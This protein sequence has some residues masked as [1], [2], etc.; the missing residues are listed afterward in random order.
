MFV[1]QLL[2]H[3]IALLKKL[4][5]PPLVFGCIFF[6]FG[7][8]FEKYWPVACFWLLV[9]SGIFLILSII[10]L[11]HRILPEVCLS[12]VIFL[13]GALSLAQKQLIPKDSIFY[14]AG[15]ASRPVCLKGNVDSE[16]A[17]LFKKRFFLLK[18]SRLI[19]EG[20]Q[21]KVSGYVFVRLVNAQN[22]F[23]GDEVI[24]QGTLFKYRHKPV[25]SVKNKPGT[26]VFTGHRGGWWLKALAFAS[27]DR[28]KK[29][30]VQHLPQFPASV[31]SAMVL[32]DGSHLA[33][34]LKSMM[35]ATGTWHILPR[36]Y[37]EMPS[38]AL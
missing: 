37:T 29:V 4:Q 27:K 34:F 12:I 31:L 23:Y 25:L 19:Q 5:F 2:S 14:L 21:H 3:F 18:V 28:M 20:R 36:L 11:K 13:F 15:S 7:I 10:F 26:L 33:P 1:P 24:V 9:S 16:N 8:I 32:G 17:V 22:Y 38:V 6:C 35:V 30:I